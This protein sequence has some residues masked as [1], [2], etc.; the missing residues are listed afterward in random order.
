MDY[1]M[2]DGVDGLIVASIIGSGVGLAFGGKDTY[3]EFK[4]DTAGCGGREVF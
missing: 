4:A 1:G 3:E 2:V